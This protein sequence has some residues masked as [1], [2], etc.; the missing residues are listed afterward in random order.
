MRNPSRL[1]TPDPGPSSSSCAQRC[2]C[3][4]RSAAGSRRARASVAP[5]TCSAIERARMPRAL[6]ITTELASSS[7]NIRL[8]TPTAGLCTQ[9][10]RVAVGKTSRS[11]KGV[12]ATSA[13]G[14][15][16]LMVS[17]SHASRNACRGNSDRS[18]ST[19]DRGMTQTGAGEI[20]PTKMFIAT[21]MCRCD[22]RTSSSAGCRQSPSIC[23]PPSPCRRSSTPPPP[24][25]SAP[26][27][28]HRS[29]RRC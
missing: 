4:A 27:S 18:C 6:V 13:S 9:R 24:P 10:N 8:P 25:Q 22:R 26:P 5:I 15:C 12:K 11:M 20:T 23:P 29:A 14:S 17:R 21:G 2:A 1:R 7:G 19:N 16:R 28:R 3:W